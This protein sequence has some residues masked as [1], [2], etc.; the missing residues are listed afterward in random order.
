MT[1]AEFVTRMRQLKTWS[2]LGFKQLEQ[3][4]ARAGYQLPHSTLSA[5]LSRAALPRPE[6][7]EAFV[8]ACG[9]DA[10]TTARWL[11]VCTAIAIKEAGGPGPAGQ[12]AAAAR[13]PVDPLP[14]NP[15]PGYPQDTM[16]LPGYP[17]PAGQPASARHQASARQ[18]IGQPIGQPDPV[19]DDP[20]RRPAR[21]A[22]SGGRRPRV[23]GIALVVFAVIAAGTVG[24]ELA[25][26]KLRSAA[27][28]AD[29]VTMI[30]VS[31]TRSAHPR[32][33]VPGAPSS[34][35]PGTAAAGS[36]R[37]SASILLPTGGWFRLR[38]M[39]AYDDKRCLSVRGDTTDHLVLALA[40]CSSSVEQQFKFEVA[41]QGVARIRPRSNR[42][43]PNACVS[44]D[45]SSSFHSVHLRTC[46]DARA[47]QQF[48]AERTRNT[49]SAG[50]LFRFLPA[51]HPAL[52]FSVPK[53][54][55]KIG[56]AVVEGDCNGT[57]YQ[58]FAVDQP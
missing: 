33:P 46:G 23:Y 8:R 25:I 22:R 52:C 47:I 1:S 20:G 40:T 34:A 7:L 14:V 36:A 30:D 45:V 15:L 31:S 56:T 26:R 3:R 41:A 4:A 18:P 12:P 16:E 6:L 42:F 50:P 29:S 24:T 5:S 10:A 2:G 37:P 58:E 53:R 28:G 44:V 35:Q 38:P 32:R 49:A 48:T 39:H 9:V 55:T 43:G 54:S 51:G 19:P 11:D 27:A 21:P 57:T 17:R 13:A